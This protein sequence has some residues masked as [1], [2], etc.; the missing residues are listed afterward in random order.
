MNIITIKENPS[1]A[2]AYRVQGPEAHLEEA[3][4]I[5]YEA[6]IEG[7]MEPARALGLLETWVANE[8]RRLEGRTNSS[9][10]E[11]ANADY[12]LVLERGPRRA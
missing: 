12:L 7:G 1:L 5:A 10:G 9:M 11:I 2:E 8:W 4:I 3:I 6:S